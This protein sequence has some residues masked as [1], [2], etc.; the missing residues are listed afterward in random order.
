MFQEDCRL[1][2]R[3]ITIASRLIIEAGLHRKQILLHRFPENRERRKV[4]TVLYTSIILDRQLN[5]AA[6]LPFTLKDT[7]IDIPEVVRQMRFKKKCDC[8]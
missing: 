6:G 3:L 7:D 5:F 8:R 1:A 2:S 4:I